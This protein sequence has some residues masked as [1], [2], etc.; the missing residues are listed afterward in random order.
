[1]INHLGSIRQTIDEA[2]TIVAA[3][4]YYAYGEI[5]PSR[6]YNAGTADEKYKFTEKERD[7]ET[8][9][10]YFGARYYNSKLGLWNSVDPLADKYPSI[11]PYT[12][13]ANNPLK[14][15]DTDG[16]EIRLSGDINAARTDIEQ[17]VK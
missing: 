8:N 11:S 1:M 10:D 12:Y 17:L 6:S 14:H 13:C 15:I 7:N 5:I 3:Q 9:Y 16:R 2:G 4:D